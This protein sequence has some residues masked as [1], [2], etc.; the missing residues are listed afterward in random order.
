[1]TASRTIA[2]L[3]VLILPAFMPA[4]HA[5]P[6]T[7]DSAQTRIEV[8]SGFSGASVTIFGLREATDGQVV[9]AVRG[10]ERPVTVR[11]KEQ[12]F[13]LWVNTDKITF[14]RTP[15][16]YELASSVPLKTLA[17]VPLLKDLELGLD[18]M[19]IQA[20][21]HT[22]PPE[23]YE[24]F[25][26]ALVDARQRKGLFLLEPRPLAYNGQ[27]LFKTSFT[28]P[29]SAP[30]GVYTVD[31]YL[32]RGNR[33]IDTDQVSFVVEHKGLAG[34]MRSFAIKNGFLYGLYGVIFA[35]CAGWLGIFLLRRE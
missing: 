15:G 2:L 19:I 35:M 21:D 16:Y 32:M 17:P 24:S 10:P 23:K 20:Q 12:V 28:L 26:N 25:Y 11:R 14:P 33:V 13:G 22:L 3:C 27:S 30:T 31:G 5:K 4:A 7:I 1:M 34:Q 18:H 9:I 6:L 8:T 29:S